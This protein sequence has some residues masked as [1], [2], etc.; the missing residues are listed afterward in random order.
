MPDSTAIPDDLTAC[1][2]LIVELASTV[3]SLHA[4]QTQLEQKLEEQELL[5]KKLTA[6]LYGRRSERHVSPDQRC[7]DF[8]DSPAEPEVAAMVVTQAEEILQE[9]AKRRRVKPK[10][11]RS[12]QLPPH[13]ERYEVLVDAPE[14]EQTCALHGAR[15]RIGEDR[16]ETLEFLRPKLRVKVSVYPKYA[17]VNHSECGIEQAPRQPALIEGGRFEASIA[18]EVLTKKF[19]VH[20]PLY[21]QQDAF[22]GLGWTPSRSTLCAIVET[23]GTLLAPLAAFYAARVL[24]SPVLGTDETPVMMLVPGETPGSRKARMWLYRGRDQAPYSVYDFTTSRERA[25]PDQ[26]LKNYHGKLMADCYSGYQKIELRTDSRILRGACWAH[27]RRKVFDARESNPL[28]A[29]LLLGM[30]RELYDIEDRGRALANAE[31]LALRQQESVPVMDR[32]GA[33]LSS[34]G[35]QRV[36]PKSP[37]G[38]ALGYIRNHWDALR[39][40]LTDGAMPI[41][42]NDVERELRLVALGRKNWLFLG[43]E[44]AGHRAATIMTVIHTAH[45]HNVDEWLYLTDILERLSQ[46]DTNY[47]AML[48]DHWKAEHPEAVRE[49]REIE[50][51]DRADNKKAQRAARRPSR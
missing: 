32:I 2:T 10:A 5:I 16:V 9:H 37:L 19:I 31:C 36:L 40:Y 18:A 49:F 8:G 38:E 4:G 23:C 51:R 46:G 21:R 48:A 15:R 43:S 1:Q 27:A 28:E 7:L 45:R 29:T 22:A 13:L 6:L 11:K 39:L 47:E 24:T 30:I 14:S 44:E 33:W 50:R 26:F 3:S 20:S 12:E 34:A 35:V 25:G 42:N 17:C 41:D